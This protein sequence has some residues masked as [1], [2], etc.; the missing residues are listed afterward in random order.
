MASLL[1]KLNERDHTKNRRKSNSRKFRLYQTEILEALDAGY[2][3][4]DIWE[5]LKE[6]KKILCSYDTFRRDLI[7]LLKQ[8]S[9]QNLSQITT[10]DEKASAI[11]EVIACKQENSIQ[12][13]NQNQNQNQKQQI[14]QKPQTESVSS[15]SFRIINVTKEDIL[16]V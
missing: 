14:N 5:T 3:A 16:C 1:K 11:K 6:D 2:L 15:K 9:E 13:E 8:R 12:I 4:R 7:N 10:T